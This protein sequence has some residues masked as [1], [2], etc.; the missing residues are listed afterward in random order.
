MTSGRGQR[1]ASLVEILASLLVFGLFAVGIQQFARTMLRGV[2]V[3]AAA[4]EAQEAARLGAQLI[5]TDLRDAGFSASGALG[6]G[7]REASADA[8]AV[9][10]DLNGD[11]DS[12]DAGEAVAYAYAA[13][14]R[15][16]LRRQGAAPPQPLLNDLSADGLRLVY[17]A[18]D[19]SRLAT[20]GALDAAQLRRIHR[21]SVQVSVDIPH[22]DPA[23][24]QPI[25]RVHQVSVVLR[26]A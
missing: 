23:F 3:L 1:G 13:D 25:R 8:V 26:N 4:A 17:F 20:S 5:A 7:V 11:G 16:L 10:R 18:R 9:V 19:G 15:A 2:A 12:D 14:R 22:P 6:N 24:G 21:V